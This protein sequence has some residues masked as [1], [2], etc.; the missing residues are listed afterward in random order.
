MGGL[1]LFAGG[2]RLDARDSLSVHQDPNVRMPGTQAIE[3][4]SL[5]RSSQCLN[6][7]ADYDPAIEPGHNW[8][9][10][11]MAQAGRDFL[12]WPAMT[13]AAQ[14]SIWLLGNPNATDLC[15]RCHFPKGWLNDAC[16]P[17]NGA[18]LFGE[19]YDGVQCSFCHSMVDPFFV[20]TYNG[21]REGDDW[22]IYWDET[23]LS[24]T[25]SQTA[26]NVTLAA[27]SALASTFKYFNGDPFFGTDNRPA[28]AT[29]TESGGGQYFIASDG[30][31][32]GPF[33][34][35][36]ANHDTYYSRYH[37]SAN[38][39]ATCHDV[40]NPVLVN[41]GADPTL[42]LPSETQSAFSYGHV[43]RTFS[44]FRLSAYGQQGGAA[45]I[46]D[47][48]P[49]V[50][51]TVAADNA[52]ARCQDCHM[53]NAPG[54]A[55]G[56]NN[57][58][59]RPIESVEHPNSGQPVHSFAGG[60]M[61]VPAVLAS[62]DPD[63]P[64]YD[65]TNETLLTQGYNVLTMDPDE[66]L[67]INSAALLDGVD[68]A[69]L[70]LTRAATVTVT[71]YED[72]TGELQFHIQNQTGHKLISGFPEGRR[73]FVNIRF[74]NGADTLIGEVNPYDN[75]VHTLK[76]LNADYSPTSPALGDNE[77]YVDELVYEVHRGSTILGVDETLHSA[78]ATHRYKD[79][80]IPPLGFRI[81]EA[82]ERLAEPVWHGVSAP[83]YFTTTE[84]AGGYD[85]V[86]LSDLGV[87]VE[88]A[89]RIEVDLYYQTVSREFVEFLRD[90]INGSA[91]SLPSPGVSGDPAYLIQS[92]PFFS[93][94]KAWGNTLWQL[95]EHNNDLPGAAPVVMAGATWEGTPTALT[96]LHG[97][98]TQTIAV[99][100]FF[101]LV[102]FV[103]MAVI[104]AWA[105][106]ERVMG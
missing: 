93:K 30:A 106:R 77:F 57:A 59:I 68:H 38:Y 54:A 89:T 51:D 21:E 15:L 12:F 24:D 27:D 42:P 23:N 20:D 46:G 35:A 66:G 44:E 104:T 6:C 61:W 90:E 53:P 87:T 78:L 50:F 41:L 103:S 39:C 105:I 97:T 64:N 58:F 14:D 22:L 28:S 32:R 19:E 81:D 71:S 11:M 102:L 43:E 83:D 40:S 75:S 16:D 31:K 52:I 100:P 92:D 101:T 8:Q 91:D 4:I 1:M 47:F 48:A 99:L 84:Y 34:D 49:D 85:A 94:L 13:V 37:K 45:G 73:M 88:G 10:S 18:S 82:A 86:N 7:H 29:Y 33:A 63:S 69:Q 65:E 70:E 3:A 5:D 76:G 62:I 98:A 60:N 17:T 55:S 80:R 74:Y 79:N 36:D 9:G 96:D 72:L 67:G 56:H 26:A 25:P 2:T 95:W